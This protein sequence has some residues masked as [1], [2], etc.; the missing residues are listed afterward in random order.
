MKTVRQTLFQQIDSADTELGSN[1]AADINQ[2]LFNPSRI[3]F[4]TC[5]SNPVWEND[6][7]ILKGV[8]RLHYGPKH[9][10]DVR[11]NSLCDLA[12]DLLEDVEER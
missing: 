3:D 6:V 2:V 7:C 4:V 1:Q 8:Y 12:C 10:I 9:Y 11:W 5:I